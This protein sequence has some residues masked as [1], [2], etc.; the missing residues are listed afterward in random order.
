MALALQVYVFWKDLLS[1]V[2]VNSLMEDVK[3]SYLSLIVFFFSLL[4]KFSDY[5]GEDFIFI[6]EGVPVIQKVCH[7]PVMI[8]CIIIRHLH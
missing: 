1:W 5:F 6:K 2:V 8:I 3:V 7:F 4:S